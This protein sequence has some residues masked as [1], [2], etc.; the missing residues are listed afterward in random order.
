PPYIKGGVTLVPV[1]AITEQLGAQVKWDGETQTVSITKDGIMI[2]MTI[3][4]H[5][6]TVSNA[7][8]ASEEE[9]VNDD[10]TTSTTDSTIEENNVDLDVAAEIT[11]GRTYVPLRFLAETFGLAVVWDDEN[12]T[13]DLDEQVDNTSEIEG[14]NTAQENL[15]AA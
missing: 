3:G 12:K 2:T 14:Q 10:T 9:T 13:I 1:S 11:N 15:P 5:I 8:E 7:P 4:S 6:V